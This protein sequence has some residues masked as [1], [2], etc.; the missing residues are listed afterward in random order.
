[1]VIPKL[2]FQSTR[3]FGVEIELNSEDRR[4]FKERP[5][6][7]MAKELPLGIFYIGQKILEIS[8]KKE[9]R[10]WKHHLTHNNSIWVLKPDSS[11]GIEVCSPIL[12]GYSGIKEICNLIEAFGKDDKVNIDSRCS[13]HTHFNVHN[14]TNE[15][16]AAI[17][18][19]WVKCESVLLDSMPAVRKRNRHCQVI[20][21]FDVFEHN[22]YIAPAVVLQ[23]LG[24]H[25]YWTANT[26]HFHYN[27]RPTIEFRIGE[28]SLCKDAESSYYWLVLLHHFVARSLSMGLPG[29]YD[30]N[31]WNGYLWLDPDDVLKFLGFSGEYEL[32]ETLEKTRVWFINRLKTNVDSRSEREI[33]RK[34]ISR[35]DI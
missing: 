28:W 19:W 22:E 34:E 6:N 17:C 26:F 24:M 13:L 2:S 31:P 21:L 7:I 4:D 9:V 23:K 18:V 3:R 20:G 32:D 5:L 25:K 8:N 15:Q 16:V 35:M 29:H 1:M 10:V 33:A 14:L 12:K 11:C 30:G 27:R